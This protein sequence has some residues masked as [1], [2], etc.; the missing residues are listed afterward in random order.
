M[1][2][3]EKGAVSGELAGNF[4]LFFG[5]IRN[6]SSEMTPLAPDEFG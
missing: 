5:Q 6:H 3:S 2:N 4:V 1:V